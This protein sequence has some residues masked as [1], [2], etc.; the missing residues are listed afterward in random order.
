MSIC[1]YRHIQDNSG[2]MSINTSSYTCPYMSIHMAIL[3][4]WLVIE[5]I[6]AELSDMLMPRL[7]VIGGSGIAGGNEIGALEA[8]YGRATSVL[9]PAVRSTSLRHFS[10][11]AWYGLATCVLSSEEASRS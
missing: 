7:V 1:M 5:A 4:G 8:P 9:S 2:R 3:V 10:S 6:I 11:T